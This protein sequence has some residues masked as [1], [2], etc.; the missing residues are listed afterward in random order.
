MKLAIGRFGFFNPRIDGSGDG[1]GLGV[2]IPSWNMRPEFL[3][4]RSM[5]EWGSVLG[6]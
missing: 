2:S 5:V 6:G 3:L 1:P 4:S